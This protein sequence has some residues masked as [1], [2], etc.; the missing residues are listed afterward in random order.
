MKSFA[1]VTTLFCAAVAS[2]SGSSS[3]SSS[4]DRRRSRTEEFVVFANRGSSSLG[5]FDVG[6]ETDTLEIIDL[7][8][9]SVVSEPMYVSTSNPNCEKDNDS[10]VLVGMLFICI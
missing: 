6:D 8:D 1:L 3:S 2:N 7:T 10:N 5:S 4:S 9:N